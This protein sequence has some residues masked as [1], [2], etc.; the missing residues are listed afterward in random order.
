M[1]ESAFANV[2]QRVIIGHMRCYGSGTATSGIG[3]PRTGS[4][5]IAEKSPGAR[6]QGTGKNTPR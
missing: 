5:G 2:A 3:T 1:R 6:A 4:R